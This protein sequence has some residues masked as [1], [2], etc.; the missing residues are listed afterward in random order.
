MS[1]QRLISTLET[2]KNQRND[3]QRS[4]AILLGLTPEEFEIEPVSLSPFELP[5]L[6]PDAPIILIM[7]RTEMRLSE[8]EL[9][10]VGI[11]LDNARD[12]WLPVLNLT[13]TANNS[14]LSIFDFFSADG[15]IGI[16]SAGLS[17]SIYENGDREK[18]IMRAEI[19]QQRSKI[20]YKQAVLAALDEIEGVLNRQQR[21][22]RQIEIQKLE[23][24]AQDRVTRITRVQ[25][26]SGSASAF[27]LIREQSNELTVQQSRLLNWSEG[28]ST[29]ISA[30]G[31]LSVD[32]NEISH[33]NP[34]TTNL[35]CTFL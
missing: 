25:Y 4:L 23:A 14:G 32:P 7:N 5:R 29:Y 21:N 33:N 10:D 34:E 22:V 27:D 11:S 28:V 31:A 2:L 3:L 20:R 12:A 9:L 35:S 13:G 6:H 24:E 26:E 30:L 16:I 19:S 17:T 15:L 1:I 8:C 18:D